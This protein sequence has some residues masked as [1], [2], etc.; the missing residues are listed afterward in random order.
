MF[1]LEKATDWTI[2]VPLAGLTYMGTAVRSDIF[3]FE[4]VVWKYPQIPL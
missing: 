4:V 2:I 1:L 3:Q